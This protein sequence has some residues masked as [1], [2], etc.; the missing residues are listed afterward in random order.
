[1]RDYND[2]AKGNN[3]QLL[4]GE[5]AENQRA[6]GAAKTEGIGKSYFHFGFPGHVWH[7]V[8]VALRVRGLIVD[9]WRDNTP[10]YGQNAE[11]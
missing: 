4:S 6:I 9:G 10:G 2:Q 8:E 7:I 5:P 1:M 3:A 11:N